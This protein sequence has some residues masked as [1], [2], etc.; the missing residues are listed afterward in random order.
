MELYEQVD[1]TYD[2]KGKRRR[3]SIIKGI[4]RYE[5]YDTYDIDT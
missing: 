5:L 2:G 4:I 1:D 3:V